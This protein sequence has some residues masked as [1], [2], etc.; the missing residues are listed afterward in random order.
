VTLR[1]RFA[2]F[3]RATRSHTL[4]AATAET[5]AVMGAIR[6]LVDAAAPLMAERGLS[7]LGVAVGNLDDTG[8]AQ[9]ELPFA[10]DAHPIQLDTAV[11][12]VRERYG[13]SAVTRATLLGRDQGLEMPMLPD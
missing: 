7:M 11:D 8:G 10:G 1:L 6:L 2:D 9:L 12:A 3:S 4:T 13:L 5:D